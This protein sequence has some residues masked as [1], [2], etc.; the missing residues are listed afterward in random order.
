MRNGIRN[1]RT[2]ND[3][4]QKCPDKAAE[5]FTQGLSKVLDTLVSLRTIQTRANYA[6][7]LSQ[8]TKQLMLRRQEAQGNAAEKEDP[9]DIREARHL[10]NTVV[11]SR[12]SDRRLWEQQKLTSSGKNQ[13]DVWKGV[14]SIFGW[15]RLRAT[16][17]TVPGGQQYQHPLRAWQHTK[18]EDFNI[19]WN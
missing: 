15:A 8:E 11:D 17:K 2:C 13:A 3:L 14:E 1:A 7:H 10:R 18:Y 9:G 19:Y 4:R 16:L 12:R 6:P 5:I